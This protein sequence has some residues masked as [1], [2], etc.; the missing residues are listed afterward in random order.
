MSNE[1]FITFEGGE[2]SGKTTQL[3]KLAAHL[4]QQG[5]SV[6]TTREPG[7]TDQADAIRALIVQKASGNWPPFAELCLVSAAR[8][9]H[10]R[11]VIA[12]ALAEGKTVLCDR[13]IDSTIAYQG[14]GH[15]LDLAIINDVTQNAIGDLAPDVTLLFDIPPTQGIARTQRRSFDGDDVLEDK[16]ESLDLS[17][18]ERVREGFLTLAKNNAE[19]FRI[20]DATQTVD[21][22]SAHV[23]QQIESLSQ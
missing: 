15:G 22:I 11:D 14:Y 8:M 7:G 20:I 13:F 12:P 17:F 2:G 5:H 1:L 21:A 18:H 19:R 9:V 6:V 10:V 3:N 23:F 16:F 4:S